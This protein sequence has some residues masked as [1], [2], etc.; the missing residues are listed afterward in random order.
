MSDVTAL[1]RLLILV[2]LALV[3]LGA[4][5][6]TRDKPADATPTLVVVVTTPASGTTLVAPAS[7]V[8][9]VVTDTVAPPPTVVVTA[10]VPPVAITP[11]P[12]ATTIAGGTA[13]GT[14]TVQWGDTLTKIASQFSTTTQAILAANPGINA[15][16]I[17]PG[18]VLKIPSGTAPAPSATPAVGSTPTAPGSALPAPQPNPGTYTVQPGDW[19]YAIA[20]KFGVS[21]Q[22]LAAANPGFNPNFVFPGQVLNIPGAMPG[23]VPNPSPSGNTYTVQPGDTLFSIAVRFRT[24]T[25]ALQIA[26]RLANPNFISPGQVLT[27]PQ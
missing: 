10:T 5:A 7:A 12:P 21:V 2:A 6:C 15:N 19:L 13:P 24:T 23:P 9:P 18:V 8:T 1:K 11:L 27:I 20:R 4:V 25:Y 22:Q 17:Y 14:Y 26:N 16:M 3:A